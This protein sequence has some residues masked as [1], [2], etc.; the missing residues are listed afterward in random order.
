VGVEEVGKTHLF[1]A[2]ER[3]TD[4]GKKDLAESYYCSGIVVFVAVATGLD[5]NL[6]A[7]LVAV[8]VDSYS[9]VGSYSVVADSDCNSCLFAAEP[10]VDN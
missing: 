8:V 4:S 6:V 9:A 2:A 1:V 10:A 5:Y 7:G 3:H